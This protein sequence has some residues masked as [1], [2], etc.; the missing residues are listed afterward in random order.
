MKG[1][2]YANWVLALLLLAYILNF[3]DRRCSRS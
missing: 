1:R 3:V 2:A